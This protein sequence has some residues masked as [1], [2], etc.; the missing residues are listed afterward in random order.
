MKKR[1]YI[2]LGIGLL[3]AALTT[4][5]EKDNT[6][7]E[8]M[9]PSALVTVKPSADNSS[10]VLQLDDKTVLK[11]VNMDKSPYGTKEVR[12]LVNF[13]ETAPNEV[14]INWLDS[15]LTKKTVANLG[16]EENVKTYGN[17]P[18][19]IV[20]DW[21]TVA[22]D[23]YLTLRFR[24]YWGAKKHAVNLV[25]DGDDTNPYHVT[26]YHNANQDFHDRIGD[27][28]VAFRLSDLPDTEGKT[29]DLTLE[30]VSFSGK[31]KTTF[32]YCSRP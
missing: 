21:V 13:R 11:P 9:Y 14:H 32:K 25:C 23:G 28:I 7:Y 4:S 2:F 20:N 22:E 26:F 10:F 5:C 27:G 31:K 3:A 6:N 18:V 16:A 8:L 17:D 15:I 29:V 30:W 24:T 12:A 1:T 19:E